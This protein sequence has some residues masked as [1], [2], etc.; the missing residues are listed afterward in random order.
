MLAAFETLYDSLLSVAMIMAPLAPFLSVRFYGALNGTAKLEETESVHLALIPEPDES[1]IDE[2]LE[3]R[4]QR[5]QTVVTLALSLREEAGKKVDPILRKVRQ[6][7]RRILIAVSNQQEQ[8]D[9]RQVEEIITEELNVKRVEYIGADQESEIV[10]IGAKPNFKSIGPKFGKDAK[11]VAAAING[12]SSREVRELQQKN[13]LVIR[14]DGDGFELHIDDIEI[15]H[16]DIEGWLVAAEGTI[17]VALDTEL[18]VELR[19][20]GLA[21]EFVN[22]VQKLRKDSGLEVTDRLR[23]LYATDQ[24]ELASALESQQ[25]Y[26]M[27]ETLAKEFSHDPSLEGERVEIEKD[28]LYGRIGLRRMED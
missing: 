21:R 4:M 28:R 7:L 14:A 19:A 12:M 22:H 8:N 2:G 6:P 15:I 10:K 23:L 24:D 3:R 5:A 13:E 20:E 27:S 17:T 26:I 16:E 25:S 9:F 1:R 18:D 11:R